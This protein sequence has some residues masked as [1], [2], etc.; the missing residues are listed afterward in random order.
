MPMLVERS[1]LL[2]REGMEEDFADAMRERGNPLLESIPGVRS[3]NMGRG[4]ENPDKFVLLVAWDSMDS[5]DAFRTNPNYGPF[6]E[7]M[8][9]F[10]KGGAMEHFNMD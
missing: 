5:H 10:L 8:A 3:V 7:I 9:P 2:V 1:E 4:V 6:R